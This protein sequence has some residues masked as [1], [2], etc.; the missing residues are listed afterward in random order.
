MHYPQIHVRSVGLQVVEEFNRLEILIFCQRALWD[1]GAGL[2][3]GHGEE[4]WSIQTGQWV[5]LGVVSMGIFKE[6]GFMFLFGSRRVFLLLL[7]FLNLILSV[8]IS[9][10]VR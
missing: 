8:I 10:T 9:L 3:N 6:E 1:F 5:V 4:G 7:F 2:Q